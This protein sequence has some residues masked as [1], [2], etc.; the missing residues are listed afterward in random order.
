VQSSIN[1]T[2]GGG[3]YHVESAIQVV[4]ILDLSGCVCHML[5]TNFSRK[6]KVNN[7][8]SIPWISICLLHYYANKFGQAET[9][10]DADHDC[11]CRCKVGTGLSVTSDFSIVV[12]ID[13]H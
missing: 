8:N 6:F 4:V 7:W 9:S 10:M 2:V 5:A 13:K 3:M 11:L 12:Y 1:V